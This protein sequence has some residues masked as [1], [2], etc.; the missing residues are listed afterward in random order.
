MVRL[1]KVVFAVRISRIRRKISALDTTL[2]EAK[3]H[4]ALTATDP[5]LLAH[6]RL[7]RTKRMKLQTRVRILKTRAKKWGIKII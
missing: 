4:I 5:D 2:L 1:M 6:Y 7:L 3:R